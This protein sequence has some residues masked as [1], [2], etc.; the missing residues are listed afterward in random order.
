VFGDCCSNSY[1]HD[2]FGVK[3]LLEN[4]P[5]VSAESV[6]LQP[7]D[8]GHYKPAPLKDPEAQAVM[9][10]LVN[11]DDDDEYCLKVYGFRFVTEHPTWGEQSSVIAFRNSSNGYYGGWMSVAETPM[12]LPFMNPIT[13]DII[14]D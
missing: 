8:P 9:D 6:K 10:A 4:G 5:V 7:G 12:I 1:F 13:D 11:R 3:K 2:F 14:G